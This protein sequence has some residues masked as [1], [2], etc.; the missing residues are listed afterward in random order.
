MRTDTVTLRRVAMVMMAVAALGCGRGND[1]GQDF[2]NLI[3]SAQGTQLTREE[4][5]TGWGRRECFLCHP[6]DEIHHVDR[7]GTGTVPSTTSG[8]WS[9]VRGSRAAVSATATT[10]WTV[11]D[12]S[13]TLRGGGRDR[14]CLGSATG[15][16]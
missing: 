3:E 2:G 8:A 16:V 7:S 13:D 15:A 9:I 14:R 1:D 6:V 11:A 12:A 5:P 10:G 4:H